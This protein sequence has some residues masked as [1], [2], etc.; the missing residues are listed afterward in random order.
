MNTM[1]KGYCIGPETERPLRLSSHDGG[2]QLFQGVPS[3]VTWDVC[4]SF[5]AIFLKTATKSP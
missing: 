4:Q 5:P 3:P 2:R 1:V